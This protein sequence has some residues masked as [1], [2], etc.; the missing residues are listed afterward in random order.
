LSNE[1]A[2]VAKQTI[3]IN[4]QLNSG[5]IDEDR[6]YNNL[7]SSQP[8]A[9]SLFCFMKPNRDIA[10]T[11]LKSIRPEITR[12]DDIVFEFAPK[13]TKDSSAFDFGF[14]VETGSGR[15]FIGFECKYTDSFSYRRQDSKIN[16]GDKSD[17]G[18]DKNF[19]NY[20]KLYT[21]NCYKF[22]D[23][24]FSYVRNNH[25]NQLFRNEL[26]AVQLKSEFDFV[27][28]GLFC[29]HDDKNAIRVGQEFQ[30]KIGNGVDDFIILTYADYFERIQKIELTWELRELVMMLWARYCGLEL[31]KSFLKN[32]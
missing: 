18:E 10:L 6:L 12:V 28:T 14:I 22:R 5:I 20:F 32:D 29:R 3:E 17:D 25:H 11:F 16:Y 30:K 19:N 9:F 21:D 1:I 13:S 7:L 23:D 4:K 26:L 8:L 31:S 2:E 24:Y 27:I 15:G